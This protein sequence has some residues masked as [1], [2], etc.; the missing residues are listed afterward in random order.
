[1]GFKTR[2][3]LSGKAAPTMAVHHRHNDILPENRAEWR[4]IAAEREVVEQERAQRQARSGRLDDA[5]M[6]LEEAA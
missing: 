3:R 2:V 1:M 4:Q 6:E 5:E